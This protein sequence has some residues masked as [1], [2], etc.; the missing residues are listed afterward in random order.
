MLPE[1][2]RV[3]MAQDLNKLNQQLAESSRILSSTQLVLGAIGFKLASSINLHDMLSGKISQEKKLIAEIEQIEQKRARTQV[4]RGA[5]FLRIQRK[6][7][8]LGIEDMLLQDKIGKYQLRMDAY[9]KQIDAASSPKQKEKI[10]LT[11]MS[12][13]ET[14]NAALEKQRRLRADNND[15]LD[16]EVELRKDSAGG[17][18]AKQESLLRADVPL[19]QFEDAL[20]IAGGRAA[21]YA[22]GMKLVTSQSWEF[23]EAL[24]DSN[25]NLDARS[26]LFNSELRVQAKIGADTRSLTQAYVALQHQGQIKFAGLD[27]AVETITKMHLGLGISL[28]T[29]SE[30]LALSR[31]LGTSFEHLADVIS[32]I[33]DGTSLTGQQVSDIAKSVS[34]MAYGFGYAGT[35]VEGTT[36]LIADLQDK[37]QRLG[38]T[39]KDA[40]KAFVTRLS[41]SEQLGGFVTMAGGGSPEGLMGRGPAEIE[42]VLKGV[43]GLV[44]NMR[45]SEVNWAQISAEMGMA[46]E[47]LQRVFN[48]ISG[49]VRALTDDEV[50]ARTLSER[51]QNQVTATN[52][53]LGSLYESFK[54]LLVEV[55]TP[56][57]PLVRMVTEAL[58]A[59]RDVIIDIKNGTPS[60]VKTSGADII[61]GL[62]A[63]MLVGAVGKAIAAVWKFG[64]IGKVTQSLLG[65]GATAGA[66][67]AVAAGGQMMLPGSVVGDVAVGNAAVGRAIGS[68]I[69]AGL[70][71]NAGLALRTF[72]PAELLA[73][74]MAPLLAGL[75]GVGIISAAAAP[76]V[77]YWY[78]K[79]RAE[80]DLEA[81]EKQIQQDRARWG[82]M[83]LSN[84][85]DRMSDALAEFGPRH[86]NNLAN[87]QAEITKD[88]H[89]AKYNFVHG[90]TTREEAMGMGSQLMSKLEG[91]EET[92]NMTFQAEPTRAGREQ[93][94][95]SITKLHEAMGMLVALQTD[96]NKLTG[97]GTKAVQAVA[98]HTH[99]DNSSDDGFFSKI[100]HDSRAAD[101]ELLPYALRGR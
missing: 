96:N 48:A 31:S 68:T 61:S 39:Q 83:M 15:L 27:A 42:R 73:G 4:D 77:W 37:M 56:L 34:E 72:A 78:K 74:G 60:W 6:K 69:L 53:S 65:A 1:L 50:K 51:Y 40:A 13:E 84:A 94:L 18:L 17:E 85:G 10:A 95:D 79:V 19:A 66:G 59:F 92:A 35:N 99:P 52:K 7:N 47:Q 55:F 54:A 32:T 28:E 82:G 43:A 67:G 98:E 9:K 64:A 46:P 101:S 57:E 45:G 76:I 30:L 97:D 49:N 87:I 75:L 70:K 58:G 25:S 71:T 21:F 62:S 41:R 23:N 100:F 91:R 11:S 24:I 63:L 5:E 29:G 93:I 88:M 22:L 38:E 14:L 16:K 3:A 36:K 90:I 2:L 8:D 33:V 81:D 26:A 12:V 20:R 80:A 89:E 44:G 86:G